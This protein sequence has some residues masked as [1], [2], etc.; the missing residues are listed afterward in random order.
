MQYVLTTIKTKNNGVTVDYVNQVER[1]LSKANVL[2][3]D[4][5]FMNFKYVCITDDPSGLSEY[6][7]TIPLIENEKIT[8]ERW[9]DLDVYDMSRYGFV[10]DEDGHAEDRIIFLSHNLIPLS[11]SQLF[12]LKSFPHS[13]ARFIED[14]DISDDEYFYL[15]DHKCEFIKFARV[16]DEDENRSSKFYDGFSIHDNLKMSKIKKTFDKD[17]EG[18]QEKYGDNVQ[19]FIEEVIDSDPLL[20]YFTAGDG[21]VG[22]YYFMDEDKNDHLNAQFDEN[23]RPNLEKLYEGRPFISTTGRAEEMQ[24]EYIGLNSHNAFQSIVSLVEVRG[25][26]HNNQYRDDRFLDINV[27]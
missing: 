19:L 25:M 8:N 4:N 24:A 20:F 27:L 3:G 22:P 14:Y 9:Y 16:W 23:I 2:G 17:P 13:H 1:L 7:E 5:E 15:K 18:I 26:G 6:V 10:E 12:F 11:S 21:T